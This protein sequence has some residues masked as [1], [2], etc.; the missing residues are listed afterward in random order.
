[1][2]FG[3]QYDRL[4]CANLLRIFYGETGVLRFLGNLATGNL[5]TCCG[6]FISVADLLWGNW[7]NGFWP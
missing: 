5:L 3:K 4:A 7:C 6:L 2:E 1:M